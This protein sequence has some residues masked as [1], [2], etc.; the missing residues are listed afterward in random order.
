[1]SRSQL[2]WS[3]APLVEIEC[4]TCP[5]CQGQMLLN[6]IAPACRG[7]DLHTFECA[8][9]DHLLKTLTAYEDPMKSRALGRWL[10]GDLRSPK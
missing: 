2:L 3:I 9:C 6:R 10:E 8:V 1:M 5:V 7:I 4:P